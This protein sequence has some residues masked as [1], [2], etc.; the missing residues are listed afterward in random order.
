MSSSEQTTM[1]DWEWDEDWGREVE[2]AVD[3]LDSAMWDALNEED[4]LEW[5]TPSGY[6]FCGCD[7]CRTRELLSVVVP[8]VLDG[9][10][11]GRIRRFHLEEEATNVRRLDSKRRT[12]DAE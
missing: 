6:P 12:D 3:K 10:A 8:I 7:T 1:H 9:F 2:V 5:E 4:G 11:A